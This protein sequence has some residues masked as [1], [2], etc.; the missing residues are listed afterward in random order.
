MGPRALPVS[1][2]RRLIEGS[3]A[4][5]TSFSHASVLNVTNVA[6]ECQ[7]ERKTVEGYLDILED[8]LLGWRL[9][10]FTKKAKR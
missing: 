6:R 1:K 8:I 10:V 7:V 9:E 4:E 2:G 5:A 3:E